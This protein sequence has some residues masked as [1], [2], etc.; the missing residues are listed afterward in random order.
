MYRNLKYHHYTLRK[1]DI[2]TC[3][4]RKRDIKTDLMKINVFCS[5]LVESVH[6]LF[7]RMLKRDRLVNP[8]PI[9]ERQARPTD[10]TSIGENTINE[11]RTESVMIVG[12][13]GFK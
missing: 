10:G 5:G 2:D 6:H 9:G 4:S 1:N 3:D 12:S 13:F 8:N 7:E 11:M